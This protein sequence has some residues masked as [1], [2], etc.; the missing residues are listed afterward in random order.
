MTS[1]SQNTGIEIPISARIVTNRSDHLPAFTAEKMPTSD[2]EEEP[3]HRGAD[4]ERERRRDPLL[5][6]LGDVRAG[7]G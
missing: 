5:D 2:S 7:S 6:L 3:D 4:A 1:P